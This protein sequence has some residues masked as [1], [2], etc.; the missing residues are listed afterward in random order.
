[1]AALVRAES[2]E[3]AAVLRLVLGDRL[4]RADVLD[5]DAVALA[6]A[7]AQFQRLGE[8]VAGFEVDERDARARSRRACG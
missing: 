3:R 4:L 2:V 7:F 1:M 5:R 6:D 8:L